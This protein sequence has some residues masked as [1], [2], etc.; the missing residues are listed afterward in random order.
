MTNES[1]EIM[2]VEFPEIKLRKTNQLGVY[3]Y[4]NKTMYLNLN[5][6]YNMDIPVLSNLNFYEKICNIINHE[7]LHHLFFI[8]H[9][10][11]VAHTL[12][13]LFYSL[14]I[15]DYQDDGKIKY[16]FTDENKYR[17]Y[18]EYWIA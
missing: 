18:V 9:G 6:I 10:Y 11:S 4:V 3:S 17:S 2:P 12:D 15:L 8:E 1:V 7:F 16:S 14:F 5:G 13:N